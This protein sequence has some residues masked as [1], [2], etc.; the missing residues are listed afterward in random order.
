MR[1]GGVKT[2]GRAD[3]Q[4]AIGHWLMVFGFLPKRL[5]IKL[6]RI[7]NLENGSLGG[8]KQGGK[9]LAQREAA[10]IPQLWKLAGFR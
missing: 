10:K 1:E 6:G 4:L 8:M 5:R 2:G 7:E 3:W 9:E